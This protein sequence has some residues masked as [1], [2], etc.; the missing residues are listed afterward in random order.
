MAC[1]YRMSTSAA[2]ENSKDETYIDSVVLPRYERHGPD[3]AVDGGVESM[4]VLGRQ[5]KY[6]QRAANVTLGF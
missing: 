3:D 4:V 5:A 2:S 6:A 1:G